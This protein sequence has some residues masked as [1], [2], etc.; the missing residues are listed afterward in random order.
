L[1]KWFIEDGSLVKDMG[2][3]HDFAIGSITVCRDDSYVATGDKYGYVRIWDIESSK[4]VKNLG[5][6]HEYAV[7][8]IC[9][10]PDSKY[11]PSKPL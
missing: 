9:F 7:C 11:F 6:C 10:T 4:R 5:K 1:K 8:A 3:A 2:K